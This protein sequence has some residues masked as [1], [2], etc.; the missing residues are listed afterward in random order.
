MTTTLRVG[1]FKITW[2]ISQDSLISKTSF[3][4]KFNK[5]QTVIYFKHAISHFQISLK[6]LKPSPIEF[7]RNLSWAANLGKFAELAYFA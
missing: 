4:T 1:V 2:L 5:S 3:F 6:P 7:F